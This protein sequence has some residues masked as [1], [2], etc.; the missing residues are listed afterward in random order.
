VGQE[1]APLWTS[2]GL[3]ALLAWLDRDPDRA[4]REYNR[5][6]R[7][8]Q[9]FFEGHAPAAVYAEELADRSIARAT[10]KLLEE[11][12]LALREP[13][14]YIRTVARYILF[15][16]LKAPKAAEMLSDPP[17][18]RRPA[19]LEAEA[20]SER[21]ME[22]LDICLARLPRADYDL[23]KTYHLY[24]EKNRA[25]ARRQAVE[26]LGKKSGAIRVR[27]YR[28]CKALEVSIRDCLNHGGM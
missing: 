3:R 8:L 26:G 21:T 17:D 4:A 25:R 24:G 6:F 14:P 19:Q 10:E 13:F 7:T 16:H 5:L 28:I 9:I 20:E 23:L 1:Q 12:E 27:V 15:E 22:C 11:P 18:P 2:E